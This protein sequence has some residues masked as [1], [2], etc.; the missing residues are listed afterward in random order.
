MKKVYFIENKSDDGRSQLFCRLSQEQYN[1]LK[2]IIDE[3]DRSQYGSG[4]SPIL[5]I[6]ETEEQDGFIVH[7]FN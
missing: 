3:L 1:F 5:W 4:Y 7:E 6:T 2:T